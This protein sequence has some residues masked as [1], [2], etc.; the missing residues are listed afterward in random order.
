MKPE[1]QPSVV[2]DRLLD[3]CVRYVLDRGL[4]GLSLRPLAAAIGTSDR[5]LIYHFGTK[6]LL[7]S[8]VI[9]RANAMLTSAVGDDA[10]RSDSTPSVGDVLRAAWDFM[11]TV[12]GKKLSRLYLELCVLSGQDPQRWV[13]AHRAMRNSWV[14]LIGPTLRPIT[15]AP[16]RQAVQRLAIDAI[17]GMLLDDLVTGESDQIRDAVDVLIE[18]I[19]GLVD[20]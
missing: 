2:R 9:E 12:E 13:T 3:L 20:E 1:P 11:S 7:V 17:D 18:L 19:E 6:D 4:I 16:R 15:S 8:A 10:V 14:A 5:M